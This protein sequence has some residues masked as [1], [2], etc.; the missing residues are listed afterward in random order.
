MSNLF[1]PLIKIYKALYL[2]AY[3][4]T[5]NYGLALVLLS[6][7]TFVV[8]YPFNKKAQQIQ[9]KE[10]KIQAVLAPQIA[11]IKKQYSGQEQYEQLQWLY[12]RYGYHPLY[13]IRSALGFVLQIPFLTAAYYMLSGLAEIQGVQW[14]FIPNLGAPDHLLGGINVLPFV[15]TLVTVIYA[16]VM[17]EISKKERLQTIG[18]GVFFL[19]LLYSA[20]SALLIFWTCNLVWSLID[21]VLS[22]KLEWLGDYVSENELAF[23]IIFALS[24]TVG[25]LVPADIYIK[26]ANQLWFS[27]KDLLKYFLTDMAKYFGFLLL[28]YV[29]CK[30]KRIKYTYLSV[31]LGV[32]LGVFLQSYIVGFDYGTFDG[33]EI[34]WKNYTKIGIANTVVWLVCIAE[35]FIRFSRLRFD[36][37]K[38]KRFV[39]PITFFIVA[40]QCVVLLFTLIK[41][42]IQKDFIYTDNKAGILTTKYIYT[43]SAKDNIIVFLLD[44]F[45]ASVFEEI[46]I[47]NP[48]VMQDFADFSYYPDTTSSF[49]FT[50]Y[51]LPEILTGMLFDPRKRYSD[52]LA[53]AWNENP[54]YKYL[55]DNSFTVDLYT[56]GNY[57]DKNAKIRNLVIKK[58]EMNQNL[59][60]RFV[61]VANF[62][63]VPHY[64][65]CL[66]YDYNADFPKTDVL[67]LNFRTYSEDDRAFYIG[68]KNGLQV[69][70]GSNSFKFYHLAGMHEPFILD[71]NVNLIQSDEKGT[72]YK[73]ALGVLKI[74]WEYIRQMRNHNLYDNATFVIMADHGY[75]NAIGSRP[76]FLMK[77]PHDKKSKLTIR[78]IPLAVSGLMEIVLQ[79]FQD[80]KDKTYDEYNVSC[81]KDRFYHFEKEYGRFIK[82]K[83]LSPAKDKK[84]WI[85]LHEVKRTIGDNTDYNVGEVIDFSLLGNSIN[86]K[87]NGWTEREE[88]LGS[89]ITGKSAE[90]VLKIRNIHSDKKEYTVEITGNMCLN[91]LPHSGQVQLY[92]NDIL[93]TNW[94]IKDSRT[95]VSAKIPYDLLKKKEPLLLKFSIDKPMESTGIDSLV[96]IIERLIIY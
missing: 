46:M 36:A 72:A 24:L 20:P 1:S 14:G 75:H 63:M 40:I 23:H 78:N 11:D 5:G 95:V 10:H 62:R 7:F 4:I 34:E 57:V 61:N 52:Y 31:L 30:H 13:A 8:L 80:T 19:L 74:V 25:L 88:A 44:M 6:L 64:L 96:F 54:F 47:K 59:A 18:I 38:I 69:K 71:E 39:K 85:P 43:I 77:R 93:I 50:Q 89:V 35:P 28:I 42:P 51:S 16:F 83:I 32:L 92:A 84:S 68:L 55:Q 12:Q 3:D 65:K 45:D 70:A 27:L 2:F 56:D 26:N 21:S 15:M 48:R 60:N 94:L 22:K 87:G 79:Q 86:Y 17:P 58:V 81:S 90:L 67:G 9:N 29:I 33:H 53:D 91:R 76:V 37:N 66:Y 82:Y 41:N 49:G 73:Q